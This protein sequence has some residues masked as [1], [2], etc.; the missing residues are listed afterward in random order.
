MFGFLK[1]SI[2][3]KYGR[4]NYVS[5]GYGVNE[6]SWILL[7]SSL[8]IEAKDIEMG[9]QKAQ[10]DLIEIYPEGVLDQEE[11]EE[12]KK[13]FV[14]ETISKVKKRMEQVADLEMRLFEC[15]VYYAI[16]CNSLAEVKKR[17]LEEY[18]DDDDALKRELFEEIW[19]KKEHYKHTH[20]RLGFI[21]Q[22]MWQ[23]RMAV[24][25][26]VIHRDVGWT[27]LKT[28]ANF[29]RPL[30]TIF[31][32]WE[33]YNLNL[34][35]FHE[36]Y[37]YKYQSEREQVEQA[38]VC[39]NKREESPFSIL[40]Y[41]LGIDKS[42]PYNVTTHTNIYPKRIPSEEK[43]LYLVFQEL[44]EHE[45]KSRFFEELNR[46]NASDYEDIFGF[47]SF[48]P[49]L[50]NLP[51]E[52]IIELPN[53]YL[54]A[55][56]YFMRA[57]YFENYAWEARGTGDYQSVGE[58]NYK[59]FYERL[60]Y[61]LEDLFK[62][63]ELEPKNRV[64]WSGLYEILSHFK[65]DPQR[66]T[67]RKEFYELMRKEAL[68]HVGCVYRI[69]RFKQQR[70]GGSF[71]ENLDW[72]REVLAGTER[73]ERTQLIIFDVMIERYHSLGWEDD[74]SDQKFINDKKIQSEVNQYFDALLERMDEAPYSVSS[75][76]IYWYVK[77]GDYERLR[78]VMHKT[79]AG[80]FDLNAMNDD[81]SDNYTEAYM[82]WIR[83]V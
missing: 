11:E 1:K 41:D 37:E 35:Q 12:L 48:T 70:W 20:F 17:A 67:R 34:Q 36:V 64:I 3:K 27:H 79:E 47:L 51:E 80:K 23:I 39:F 2:E 8:L 58:E 9:V 57:N 19:E 4:D 73:G 42:Y 15:D 75:S 74:G 22:S 46:L 25:F 59:L 55:C 43:P 63:H 61:A 45:D 44:L 65:R 14:I 33:K 24:Y 71:E 29:A 83:S 32:S 78:R 5:T 81:Y 30:M 13:D 10:H 69:S 68:D 72:A 31:S 53:E 56:A 21:A 18:E 38:K 77:V 28:L 26:G 62:A 82:L 6:E 76:L 66:N 49:T 50:K 40:P 54:N 52:D 16:N 60:N 7:L